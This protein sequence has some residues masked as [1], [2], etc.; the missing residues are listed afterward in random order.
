MK[1]VDGRRFP[2]VKQN[3]MTTRYDLQ[4]SLSWAI[5]QMLEIARFLPQ[6]NTHISRT[7]AI[8]ET[9]RPQ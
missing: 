7:Y 5:R 3:A 9:V 8:L 1:I 2:T 4:L 6:I